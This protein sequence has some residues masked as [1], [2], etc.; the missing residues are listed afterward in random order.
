MCENIAIKRS[1]CLMHEWQN[2]WNNAEKKRNL[3]QLCKEVLL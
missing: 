1:N 3:Y 2:E